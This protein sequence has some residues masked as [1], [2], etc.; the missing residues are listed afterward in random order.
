MAYGLVINNASGNAMYSSQDSTWTLLAYYTT[1]ANTNATYTGVPIMSSRLVTR[2][3]LN[4]VTGDDE[5]YA[6]SY[7]LSG[8]TLTT[9]A[10]SSTDTVQTFFAVWGK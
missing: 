8:S 1:A 10:P 5:A 7:S 9:T 6:H 4:Q 3:M 2:Q